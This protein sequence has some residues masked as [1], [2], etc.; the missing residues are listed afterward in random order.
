MEPAILTCWPILRRA[1]ELQLRKVFAAVPARDANALKDMSGRCPNA[2]MPLRCA[3]KGGGQF[4]WYA[5]VCSR[6]L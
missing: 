4:E 1:P 2:L 6:E 3:S 5:D